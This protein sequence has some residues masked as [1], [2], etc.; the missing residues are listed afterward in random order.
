MFILIY[1]VFLYGFLFLSQWSVMT[2]F[3][4]YHILRPAHPQQCLLFIPITDIE[5]VGVD[6]II[7]LLFLYICCVFSWWLCCEQGFCRNATS[8]T[9]SCCNK[10]YRR[11]PELAVFLFLCLGYCSW[12]Q[13]GNPSLSTW[14]RCIVPIILH[15]VSQFR[16]VLSLHAVSCQI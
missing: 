13:G 5:L 1:L 6:Y 3:V 16:E 8:F 15:M 2:S 9:W 11:F 12:M 14:S 4:S 7:F 10:D